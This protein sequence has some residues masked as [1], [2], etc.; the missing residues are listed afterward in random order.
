MLVHKSKTHRILGRVFVILANFTTSR[1]K[2]HLRW[3]S[4]PLRLY[5]IYLYFPNYSNHRMHCTT[6]LRAPTG[7]SIVIMTGRRST[8]CITMPG[9]PGPGVATTSLVW[10]IIILSL[11]TD[12]LT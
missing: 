6:A 4:K 1:L 11:N 7:P 10:D 3:T 12:I 9:S 5:T 2:A 8:L